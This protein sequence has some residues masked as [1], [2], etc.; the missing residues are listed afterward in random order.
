MTGACTSPPAALSAAATTFVDT[1]GPGAACRPNSYAITLRSTSPSPLMLPPPCASLTSNDVHP[2]SAPRRQYPGSNPTGS[3]RSAQ[4]LDRRLVV[5]EAGGRLLEEL[6]V[7][8]QIQ[9]H[10]SI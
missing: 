6:L 9:A 1:S 10:A 4:R 2:S 5:E 7:R 8:R 3:L